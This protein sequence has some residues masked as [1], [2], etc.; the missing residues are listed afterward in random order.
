MKVLLA[1]AVAARFIR[2]VVF[3][4]LRGVDPVAV[5]FTPFT[6]NPAEAVL[7]FFTI[8]S[9]KLAPAVFKDVFVKAKE[10]PE[11]AV[12]VKLLVPDVDVIFKAPV[13]NVNPFAAV[14]VEEKAPVPV[15]SSV[16]VGVKLLIPTFPP[17]K[18]AE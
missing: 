5:T 13:V 10:S 3:V 14:K 4:P 9:P 1:K 17:A 8:K 6:D 7:L 2:L 16:L 12:E 11:V 15:T 18:I